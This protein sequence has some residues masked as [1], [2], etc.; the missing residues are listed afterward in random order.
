MQENV[1]FWSFISSLICIVLLLIIS[2][3]DWNSNSKI[4]VHP[5]TIVLIITV[6]TFLFG[7]I[8][9]SGVKDWKGMARSITT[10]VVTLSLSILLGYVLLMGS[11]FS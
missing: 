2:F 11:L 8:G 7:V 1:N 9:F 4:G 3:S 6:L 5:L 10:V